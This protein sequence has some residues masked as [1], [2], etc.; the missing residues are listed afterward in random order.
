MYDER[1]SE[2]GPDTTVNQR[3]A[4]LAVTHS[5]FCREKKTIAKLGNL[6]VAVNDNDVDAY[7]LVPWRVAKAPKV[8]TDMKQT[9]QWK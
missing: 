7:E 8:L 3:L 4:Q 6:G 9:Q 2:Q 5:L 1:D